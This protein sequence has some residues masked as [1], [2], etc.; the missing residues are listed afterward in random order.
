MRI[1]ALD[2]VQKN[3]KATN[4]FKFILAVDND[5]AGNEFIENFDFDKFPVVKHLPE[6]RP[7]EMKS[8]WNQVLQNAKHPIQNKFYERVAEA[9]NQYKAEESR[10]LS[11][12]KRL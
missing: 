11:Q 4:N 10:E 6:L 1:G 9:T 7:G 8:D 3:I 5:K 2:H 12:E